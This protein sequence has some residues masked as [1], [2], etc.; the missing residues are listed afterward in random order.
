MRLINLLI[1][2]LVFMS[3]SSGGASGSAS[4][5]ASQSSAPEDSAADKAADAAIPQFAADSAYAHVGRQLSFGPRVPGSAGHARCVDYIVSSLRR[6]GADTVYIQQGAAWLADGKQVPVRNILA[7]FNAAAPTRVL[8]AAHYDTRPWADEDPDASKHS[9]PIPGA[10]DGGS[11]VGVAL[12]LARLLGAQAPQVGV[13]FFFTDVEDSGSHDEEESD[14]MTSSS[15]CK[16][17]QYWAANP[18]FPTPYQP[19]YGILLDMVGGRDAKFCREYL[20]ER[21]AP[22]LNARVWAIAQ[23]LGVD[24][25]VNQVQGAVTD[26]HLYINLLGIPAI[27]IIECANPATGSFPPYWHTM[28]DDLSNISSSTLGD[29]G[30]VVTAVIYMEQ[31]R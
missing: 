26:D 17:A 4:A 30:K 14:P 28:A 10:N 13:D 29:V 3:C 24:R 31:P 1:F 22:Q 23:R 16:G 7:S 12:E 5:A 20:S 11:G 27:D 21:L 25:F 18:S 2:A 15:W 6:Y 9:S 8:I 19:V